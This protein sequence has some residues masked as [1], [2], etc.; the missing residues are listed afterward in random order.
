[1][2]EAYE[3]H[4]KTRRRRNYKKL[5]TEWTNTMLGILKLNTNFVQTEVGR[6]QTKVKTFQVDSKTFVSISF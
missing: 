1:V 4:W 5:L 6:F 2:I 3:K